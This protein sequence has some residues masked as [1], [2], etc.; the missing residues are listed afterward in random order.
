MSGMPLFF[1]L[2][3]V[4]AAVL[5]SF[6]V[7]SP[8]RLRVKATALC[9]AG[10]F[11]P[12]GYAGFADLLSRPKPV[13]FEW[14]LAH[15]EEA[16][17]LSSHVREGEALYLWLK[18]E[19]SDEPRAYRLPWNRQLAQQLQDASREAESNGSGVRMRL[20]FEPSL[21]T[22][23]PRFYALPQPALPP[24]D[25]ERGTAAQRYVPPGQDA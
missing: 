15:A 1:A 18:V 22:R 3:A 16:T 13:E 14:W 21:D 17:V 5:G 20:P 23:E 9:A 2:A 25:H 7:W 10:L 12:L 24:K 19:G 4:L 11:M 8:R 6:A